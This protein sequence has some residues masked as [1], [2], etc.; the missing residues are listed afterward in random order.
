M[1][2]EANSAYKLLEV[3]QP[4]SARRWSTPVLVIAAALAG[5]VLLLGDRPAGPRAG[6][7]RPTNGTLLD[8]ELEDG[9]TSMTDGM[10]EYLGCARWRGHTQCVD[11]HCVCKPGFCANEDGVCL[12]P[13][14]PKCP[15]DSGGTCYIFGCP[16]W[17]GPTSCVFGE[18]ICQ[19]GCGT[20]FNGKCVAEGTCIKD[21]ADTCRF[22]SCGRTRGPTRCELG[23]CVCRPGFCA[24]DNG[25]GYGVCMLEDHHG[26]LAEVVAVNK[27][28]P[29]FPGA[30][31][32]VK[33]GLAFSGGGA[34]ALSN[35][36]GAYR[37]LE[38]LGL[39]K[40]VDAISSVSGGTWA[41][42]IY[43]FANGS[44]DEIL[45]A[46]TSPNEL[47]M[48]VLGEDPAAMGKAMTTSCHDFMRKL[49]SESLPSADLW[50]LYVADTILKPFG[51]DSSSR[52]MAGSAADMERIKR[53]NPQLRDMNFLFPRADRPRVFIMG[54][55]ILAPLGYKAG[56]DNAVGLQMS[57]D[58]TGSPFHP[59]GSTMSY[60]PSELGAP[61]HLDGV[62]VGG[63]LVET[64]AFGGAAPQGQAGGEA[65]DLPPP[66][67]PFT[68]SY[69]VGISSAAPSALLA[70]R[71][72]YQFVVP[73]AK[74]WPV[75][76]SI[77]E[78]MDFQLG[79][80]GSMENQGLLPL[81]QRG[82]KKVA[83]W[84]STYIRLST[85]I[86]FCNVPADLDLEK[87][88]AGPDTFAVAPMV[89]DKFGYPYQDSASWYTKNQVF[90]RE[91]LPPLLCE[92]QK[93]KVAGKPAVHRSSHTVLPNSWWGIKGGYTVDIIYVYLDQIREFEDK[94]PAD[95]RASLGPLNPQ[96]RTHWTSGE[97]A[98]Y[99]DYSTVLETG[100]MSEITRLTSREVNLLAAQSEYAVRQ[101]EQLFREV[102]CPDGWPG[103][104]CRHH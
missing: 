86:D 42:S 29:G 34:R 91:E 90:D 64:F 30:H 24:K 37:A 66:V 84:V 44:K 5:L 77:Q 100:E 12:D 57:P 39:M 9:C 63:G 33:T 88:F 23:K 17:R 11:G 2:P 103:F 20:G 31:A 95:T 55:T 89:S 62:W 58:F 26:Y 56:P 60:E 36:M 1:E 53:L 25:A 81:L 40:H 51:L 32:H 78:A 13:H 16:S 27:E 49:L 14:A 41:S 4:H 7:L 8:E 47:H 3:P 76:S 35:S 21:T 69:A 67:Q 6:S 102:L 83:V 48:E 71:G 10:C 45:G 73:K 28:H 70:K 68:L 46:A 87:V 93:L 92:L 82:A 72:R 99:P 74:L 50:P 96:E 18:C 80:G 43:M 85:S 97:F 59:G 22:L 19:E 98:N 38:D 94:L 104:F 15:A 65:V 61:E 52:F 79:D 54:G 101:N 75:T